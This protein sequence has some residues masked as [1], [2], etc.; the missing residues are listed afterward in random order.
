MKKEKIQSIKLGLMI[1]TGLLLFIIAIYYL[2]SRQNLFSSSFTL[3]SYF[4]NV[5]GLVEGNKVRYSGI[6]V[7]SVSGI[8][9]IKDTTILVEMAVDKKIEKFIRKDSKVEIS[10]DGLMG[11]KIVSILPGTSNAGPVTEDDFLQTQR[12]VDMQDVLEDAKK[13]IEEGRLIT[14]NILEVSEKMNNGK[15]D[16]AVLLND[17][18]IT[19]KL[20]ETGDELLAFASNANDI[21][22]E[23]KDGKGD[24]G[25]LINDT[26]ITTQ[27]NDVM[28]N[29]NKIAVKT[30]SLTY[31]LLLFSKELNSGEG[32]AHRL[33]YDT[34]MANNIDTTVVRVNNGIDDIQN[35][36][37]TIEHSWIFNLFSKNKKKHKNN[38]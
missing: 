22:A 18:T 5:N 30:D 35:A 37:N 19:S 25:K 1:S 7:G 28:Q 13:F 4:K 9:I 16:F 24:L 2:G 12:A 36:A 14:K 20:D 15:G 32:I 31:Q 6:T 17:N 21:S 38:K 27:I 3:K 11:N 8:Q 10:S 33:V 34:L 26:S 29:L 23:V